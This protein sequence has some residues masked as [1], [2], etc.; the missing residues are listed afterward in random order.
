VVVDAN[1]NFLASNSFN[2][3]KQKFLYGLLRYAA[4]STGSVALVPPLWQGA[5]IK[6][7]SGAAC[8]T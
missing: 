5:T 4:F 7:L 8:H 2:S 6:N 3:Q 1:P